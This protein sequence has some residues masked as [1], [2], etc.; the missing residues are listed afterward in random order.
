VDDELLF[1]E[2]DL[3]LDV[4]RDSDG[5]WWTESNVEGNSGL[6]PSIFFLQ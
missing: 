5:N 2:G 1:H 6:S 3:I 4:L